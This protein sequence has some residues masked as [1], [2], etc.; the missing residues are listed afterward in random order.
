MQ[1]PASTSVGQEEPSSRMAKSYVIPFVLYVLGTNVAAQVSGLYPPAYVAVVVL[2]GIVTW[3]LLR[4]RRIV[5]PHWR[6]AEAVVVGLVG[7]A[8]WIGLSELRLEERIAT[9]LPGWLRPGERIG[10]NPFEELTQPL[11]A[12]SFIAVRLIGL[13]VLV[14]VAEELFWRGF[15]L[16]WIIS[17]DW[18]DVPLGKFSTTSFLLVTLLFMLAHPEWLAAACYCMLLNGLL[19]WKRD[20]WSCIVAHGVSNLVLGVYVLSTGTWWLW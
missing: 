8:L 2:G 4:G 6:V 13:A 1:A 10:F 20:L 15:L 5:V 11:A 17:P 18:Q 9:Y 19:N 12:W 7:I 14:P 16:R 3:L